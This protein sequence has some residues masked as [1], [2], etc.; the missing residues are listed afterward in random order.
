VEKFSA[1][2]SLF[3]KFFN[4]IALRLGVKNAQKPVPEVLQTTVYCFDN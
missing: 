2:Y 4:K 1:E 3:I